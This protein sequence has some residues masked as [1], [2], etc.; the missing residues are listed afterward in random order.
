MFF[1]EGEGRDKVKKP[2]SSNFQNKQEQIKDRRRGEMKLRKIRKYRD[3]TSGQKEKPF[4][5]IISK[6]IKYRRRRRKTS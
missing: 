2:S 1:K 4:S 3:E 5:S 6:R